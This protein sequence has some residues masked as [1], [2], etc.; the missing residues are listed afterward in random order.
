MAKHKSSTFNV[1]GM[2]CVACA[3][4]LEKKVQKLD[5][6]TKIIVNFI[7]GTATVDFYPTTVKEEDII[8]VANNM[9]Y[10]LAPESTTLSYENTF[11]KEFILVIVSW[12]LTSILMIPMLLGYH[13]YMRTTLPYLGIIIAGATIFIPGFSIIKSATKSLFSGVM[14]MDFLI[15]LGALAAWVSSLLPLFGVKI[16]DYSVT[17]SMLITVNLT[18]RLLE[19][20][21]RGTA[22]KA[23]SALANFSGK[24]AHLV[25]ADGTVTEVLV[26]DLKIGDTIQVKSGEKIPTDGTIIEGRTSTDESFL[27]G[28]SIPIEKK[29]GDYAYGG[30]LNL[31]GFITIKVE[32]DS[33][34][35]ML[36][37]TIKLIK[38]AQGT[39]VPIQV[40]A[41]NITVVFVPIL[42]TISFLSFATWFAF[43]NFFPDLLSPF[44]FTYDT[45]S[46]FAPA[47]SAAIAVLVIA[48]PCALGL[49]TPM[50]LV[51]GSTLG[52]K[53]GVLIRRGRAV[54]HLCDIDIIAL[55][56]TGTLT[57]G[58]PKVT[59]IISIDGHSE[60]LKILVGLEKSSIHPIA[61]AVLA[62]AKEHKI[63]AK[64]L[65]NITNN[66]GQGLQGTI[67]QIE[68]FA[69]SLKATQE[70]DI[71]VSEE[72]QEMIDTQIA[73]HETLVCLSNMRTKNCE[74]VLSF[75]D[76]LNPEAKES[77]NQLKAMGKKI[78]MITGDHKNAAHAVATE[79]DITSVMYECSPK[80]KLETI[81]S[82]QKQNY[83]VCFVGDGIND[84]A[85]LEQ[86][87]VG[88]AMGTGTDIAAESGDII[89]VTGSLT[90]LVL[91]FKVA[92]ATFLKIKQNL[93]WAFF[94]NCV[95]IPAA[96]LG[97]L[98][99]VTAEIAMTFSSLTV[100][101]NSILLS[102]KNLS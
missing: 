10:S 80:Q 72:L 4:R 97:L 37:Q 6:V 31:D 17:A 77:M 91:S 11:N 79:L 7:S 33:Q 41:D 70:Q 32:R 59:N 93:F 26:Q 81:K 24:Y 22:S 95:A 84:A 29:P 86:A 34:N 49:A 96:F 28:E 42:L 9:G 20:M 94:Y 50:A 36:A 64:T 40:L 67:D 18:G 100:I 83:K 62:Y 55:D 43:P 1:T 102:K 71:T 19:N 98:H 16:P 65:E 38:E 85:A 44:G 2:H 58:K 8:A 101:G 74:L 14:G 78:I 53:K 39:K 3:G 73:L 52:A 51:N 30:A 60:T 46:R 47:L 63:E 15:A 13:H 76:S 27:T 57:M 48:C 99:P 89:L 5:G 92:Q 87:N 25:S 54:Q 82:L 75:S 90:S 61:H 56:K 12:I 88:I 21:A 23:I 68:W 45:S 66:P 69:G 35:N